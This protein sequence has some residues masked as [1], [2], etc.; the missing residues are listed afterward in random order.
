M[1]HYHALPLS[2]CIALRRLLLSSDPS[3]SSRRAMSTV[4]QWIRGLLR[5]LLSS[6]LVRLSLHGLMRL[7]FFLKGCYA[8]VYRDMPP[9]RDGEGGGGQRL[10]FDTR[11]GESVVYAS[12][13]PTTYPAGYL[14]QARHSMYLSADGSRPNSRPGSRPTSAVYPHSQR[15]SEEDNQ[16]PISVQTASQQS[17][18]GSQVS[19]TSQPH[20]PRASIY[21]DHLAAPTSRP[22]SRASVRATDH[23]LSRMVTAADAHHRRGRSRSRAPEQKRTPASSRA[24]PDSVVSVHGD[25]ASVY[26]RSNRA[27]PVRPPQLPGTRLRRSQKMYPALATHRYDK[28]IK[29]QER[30]FEYVVQPMQTSYPLEDVPVEWVAHTH[31]EGCLYFYNRARRTYTEAWLCDP[32]ILEEI[33]DF[34]VRLEELVRSLEFTLPPDAELVLELERIPA[35]APS[36]DDLESGK[37]SKHYWTYY[38]VDHA[39]RVLFWIHPYSV[40]DELEQLRGFHSP[41][42]IKHGIEEY[43][44][45]HWEYFPVYQTVTDTLREEVLSILVYR[46]VDQLTSAASTVGMKPDDL[47]KLA[48][49]IKSAKGLSANQYIACAIG[50]LMCLFAHDRYHYYYG[51]KVARLDRYESLF[52]DSRGKRTAL[53][54]LLSPVLFN[55]PEVHLRSLERIWID[56]IINEIPWTQFIHKLQTDWQEAVLTA[57][58]LL[59]ANISFMTINDVD[60]GNGPRTPAQIASFVSTI[61]S[62]AATVIGMLLVRQYRVKPKETATDAVTYLTSRR[63]PKLGLETLAIM[64]SLP[65][66]LLM[67]AVVTF[68]VA[69]ALECFHVRDIPTITVTATTWGLAAM[70]LVL[71]LYTIWEGGDISIHQWLRDAWKTACE[72]VRSVFRVTREKE[73]EEE[74]ANPTSGPSS[75]TA[76][77]EMMMEEC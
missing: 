32:E 27:S 60:S 15:D 34:A 58:V 5:Q 20:R 51:Q 44:W 12:R 57:T 66:A 22:S 47:Q 50:R 56:Q 68:L 70:L 26:S 63:H 33:E 23:R 49:V 72:R 6:K 39:E 55:A 11:S 77:L 25:R 40:S 17:L 67:W 75:D 21:G 13:E 54:A 41:S 24:R 53:A 14:E 59:N 3:R 7:W 29:L 28:G 2:R 73:D 4:L 35:H 16:Y 1:Y 31:P 61:A 18:N 45:K 48:S 36:H 42:H 8:R 43:Y 64:Y 76:A 74:R 30:P 19:F 37:P 9:G 38:Y 46:N 65:Y 71:C 10:S 52:D 62:I 69:F